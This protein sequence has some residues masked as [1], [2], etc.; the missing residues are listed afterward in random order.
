LEGKKKG[1]KSILGIEI[2]CV[3]AEGQNPMPLTLLAETQEGYENLLLLAT[4]AALQQRGGQQHILIDDLQKRGNGLLLITGMHRSAIGTA[5]LAEDGQAL[6]KLTEK[7]RSTVGEKNVYFE[8][9][10]LPALAGQ[11]EI[12]Q[13]LTHWGKK[14]AVPLVVTCPVHYCRPDDAEAHDVLL[15]IK[16]NAQITDPRRMSMREMDLSMRPFAELEKAFSHVPKALAETLVIAERCNVA[17]DTATYRI[18]RFPVAAGTTEDAELTRL[19]EEG[20][21][22]RYPKP[23][24]EIR[25]RL[26]YELSVIKQVGFSGYFL[27]VADFVNEAK[28]RQITVGPGRGS[29]AGSMVAYCLNITTIEP[30]EHGLLFE[31]FLNPERITMPDFDID[32]ADTRRDEVLQY[33]REKYGADHVVQICTFGTLA[34]RAA[35]KD[36]GRVYGVPFLEMNSLAKLIPDRPGTKLKDALGIEELKTVYEQNE[37]YH[38]IIDAAL[39]LEGKARHVSV[40]ACGVVITEEPAVKMTALQRAPKDEHIIITQ[41]AAKPLEA[42]GL[43]KMD[44]LGLTNLT[45]IQHTL[46]TIRR[47]HGKDIAL[48]TLPL[49]DKKTFDLLRRGETTGV[50]Q[51]ESAGMKRYLKELKPTQF[52]DITAMVSLYR[53]GPMEW[54]PSFVKR[55]Q[56]AEKVEYLHDALRPI[57]E[58]T[59]GIGVYQ[60]Q[61]LEIARLFAGFSL[62]EADILRRAIGKKIRSELA[63]QREKFLQGAVKKGY[64]QN[65]AERIFDDVIEPF[66]GYGF[67]KSHATGYARIAYETA[68][69]KA[70]YPTEFMAA[71]L[72]SDDA[73]P[74]RVLIEIEECH[75]MGI[76]VLPPDINES[77]AQFTP[78]STAKGKGALRFGLGAIKGV[79]EGTVRTIIDIR[80]KDGPYASLEDFVCR[81]PKNVVNKKTLEALA[82]SGAL[83]GLADRRLVLDNY[84]RIVEYRKSC[85]DVSASQ[86]SLFGVSVTEQE[87]PK[88]DFP[89]TPA[90]TELEKL[91]WEKQALG[92]YVSSHP[93]AGLRKYIAKK[94][95]LIGDLQRK[96]TGKRIT[97]AGLEEGTRKITT[98][99]G[100]AMAILSLEDPTGKIE[101]T[102]FPRV[103]AQAHEVLGQPDTVLVVAGTL[104]IRAGQF[105]LVAE[106]IKRASLSTM[107]TRAKQDGFF[108]EEEARAGLLGRARSTTTQEETVDVVDDE[109]NIVAGE[110]MS[111]KA[112]TSDESLG[113]LGLW[114]SEGMATEELMTVLES[115]SAPEAGSSL[116]VSLAAEKSANAPAGGISVHTI[117]LPPRAPKTLLV[118]LRRI[119]ERF[120]GKERVELKIGDQS[121]AIPLTVSMSTVLEKKLEEV[122]GQYSSAKN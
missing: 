100:E 67:N 94:A 21:K 87:K 34:A 68:Y 20:F 60:E 25:Q 95:E 7:Y 114:I 14:L 80:E 33:V 2:L 56:G 5:A 16:Q 73:K 9:M 112:D 75:A 96:D 84:E 31:R 35:V 54:L 81:L 47:L 85:G 63:A 15:C 46:E 37:T 107:I 109:G 61:V 77:Q 26:E 29:A 93:L 70:H 18:P 74:E 53:P 23:T 43:L 79:G 38:R 39:K 106:A 99:K 44:F 113:P 110:V 62:A 65:L 41:Y 24:Q 12:N 101:V 55:K 1:I 11:H 82:Q 78:V 49:D 58:P 40:H 32:F 118:E 51:L 27:I 69:L 111:M 122:I 102:L 92:L 66:A 115:P 91:K 52:S 71:L 6:E 104:E 28:R 116:K 3:H 45:V 13:Q 30:L 64:A 97:L 17:F 50:F 98:K 117:H 108:D 57:L 83:D 8:L 4:E 89:N 10:D 121:I 105:Q 88:I 22:L 86:E 103:Y 76:R 90:A 19:C 48:P 120:P 72:T 36:V 42:L 119:L 59:Y